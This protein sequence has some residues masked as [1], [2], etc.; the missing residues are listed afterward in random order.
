[1]AGIKAEQTETEGGADAFFVAPFRAGERE[2]R[3]G[4]RDA[5]GVGQRPEQAGSAGI[6]QALAHV[7]DRR[8]IVVGK[9]GAQARSGLVLG[10]RAAI[11]EF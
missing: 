2:R 10:A 5:D 6:I 8:Q 9:Q 3:R 4:Q 1:M 11:A 7:P